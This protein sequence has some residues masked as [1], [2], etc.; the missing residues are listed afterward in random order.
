MSGVRD[1]L[2]GFHPDDK[3]EGNSVRPLTY[4]KEE[5]KAKHNFPGKHCIE[6]STE[7]IDLLSAFT[8]YCAGG[9]GLH[10]KEGRFLFFFYKVASMALCVLIRSYLCVSL[11]FPYK[12]Y[13][14]HLVQ[15]DIF[16]NVYDSQSLKTFQKAVL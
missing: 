6:G 14:F 9:T 8:R 4:I 10:N 3:W 13:F 15:L 5:K 7:N 1:V 12:L 11:Y 2:G 16:F